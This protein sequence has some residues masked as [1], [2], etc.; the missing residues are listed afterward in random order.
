MGPPGC[1]GSVVSGESLEPPG[2]DETPGP[3]EPSPEVESPPVSTGVSV[4]PV[5]EVPEVSVE[6]G[7]GPVPVEGPDEDEGLGV[8]V[9]G[10][11]VVPVVE[12]CGNVGALLVTSVEELPG[13]TGPGPFE[14]PPSDEQ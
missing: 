13:G 4:T 8:D 12:G 10:A 11:G 3:D 14:V 7:P 6:I 5:G 1:S 2:S 9:T